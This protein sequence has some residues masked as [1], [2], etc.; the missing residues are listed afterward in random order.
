MMIAVTPETEKEIE[1]WIAGGH[2][3]D[4]DHV[5]SEAL[6]ALRDREHAKFLRTRELILAGRDS[7]IAGELTDEFWEE[8]AREA[9]EADR[10]GLP[11]PDEV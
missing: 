6:Q 10:L 5:I 4:A 1:E 3:R 7:G 2:F 11:I 8:I 9:E